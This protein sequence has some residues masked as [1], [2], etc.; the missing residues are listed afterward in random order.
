MKV[1]TAR[2]PQNHTAMVVAPQP[3]ATDAGVEVL[4]KGG[5]VVDAALAA[6]LVQGVVD[7]FACGIGGMAITQITSRDGRVQTFDG[8][9]V[10]PADAKPGMWADGYRGSFGDELGHII[11]SSTNE[12]GA[13]SVCVPGV[14]RS[15]AYIHSLHGSIPWSEVLAPA[16]RSAGEYRDVTLREHVM[17]NHSGRFGSRL[18]IREKLLRNNGD[19]G[20]FVHR[21][22]DSVRLAISVSNGSLAST[23]ERMARLGADDFYLGGLAGIIIESLSAARGFMTASD[24]AGYEVR[25]RDPLSQEFR[26]L[27]VSVPADP[28]AGPQL[29]ATLGVMDRFEFSELEHNSPEH[30]RILAESMKFGRLVADHMLDAPDS[31]DRA[32][33]SLI[34]AERLDA[35]AE[36]IRSGGRL[37]LK[38][39][40]A[41]SESAL[42]MNGTHVSVTDVDG[43]AVSISQ[44]LGRQSGLIVKST[45]FMVNGGMSLFDPRP[46]RW[47]SIAPGRRCPTMMTPTIVFDG[48]DPIISIGA[49]D[50][51]MAAQA[52]A[53]VISNVIDFGMTAQEAVSAPRVSATG[54]PIEISN[55][56][57]RRVQADL[58][59]VGY[60]VERSSEGFTAGNAYAITRF[61]DV[62][63]GGVD[64][65]RDGYAAGV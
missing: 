52:L 41:S 15:F 25:I 11:E 29:L 16:I 24:L 62:L 19:R 31:I 21:D 35:A 56:I 59:R 2:P 57:P 47:S 48:D 20:G 9:G 50:G 33:S 8:L 43:M 10:V 58:E 65:C 32:I 12:S 45:G 55:R 26:G 14:M 5:N 4:A 63:D 3:A 28:V 44:T 1:P 13:Q 53:Q 34:T 37:G 27:R 49:S 36:R 18:S 7:P 30:I 17:V 40:G 64:P 46:G 54:R 61:G 38:G 42:V 51:P 60:L 6:A 22:G 39:A 23:L